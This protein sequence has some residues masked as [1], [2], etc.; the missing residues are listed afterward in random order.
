ME[1]KSLK[2]M[3]TKIIHDETKFMRLYVGIVKDINDSMTIGRVLV[4]IPSLNWVTNDIAQ[5]C[6]PIDKNCFI[7]PKLNDLVLVLFLHGDMNKSYYI[8]IANDMLASDN[9]GMKPKDWDSKTTTQILFEDNENNL[10]VKYDGNTKVYEIK[11]TGGND[12]KIDSN[13]G[14]TITDKNTNKIELTSTGIKLTDKNT[15]TIEMTTAEV[16]INSTS[17]EVFQ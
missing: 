11:D 10:Y 1:K 12:I 7:I 5:W 4:Q 8:G 9:Q 6:I 2:E 15:N 14:I 17:L 3:I 13:N 16:K